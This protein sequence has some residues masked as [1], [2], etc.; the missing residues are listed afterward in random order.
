MLDMASQTFMSA[1]FVGFWGYVVE[2]A[3]TSVSLAILHLQLRKIPLETVLKSSPQ[4]LHT[5]EG[6]TLLRQSFPMLFGKQTKPS[7]VYI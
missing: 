5:E 1:I 7:Y 3:T 6:R 2:I 4:L